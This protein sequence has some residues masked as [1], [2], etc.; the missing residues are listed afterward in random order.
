LSLENEKSSDAFN[1]VSYFIVEPIDRGDILL[2][3]VLDLVKLLSQVLIVLLEEVSALNYVSVR[4]VLEGSLCF[5]GVID[6]GVFF[7]VGKFVHA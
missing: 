2:T 5:L 3:S 7:L 6:T 1:V 4:V